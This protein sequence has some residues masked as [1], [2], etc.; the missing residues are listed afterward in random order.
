MR[1]SARLWPGTDPIAS[2]EYRNRDLLESAVG[3]PFH[4]AFG[5]DAYPTVLEK[6]A[7]LFHS[8]IAN[9]PFHNGN[10]RTAVLAF[11][12]FLAA[13]GYFGL[14]GNEA[15][16]KLAEQTASYKERGVSHADS[17]G[18]IIA[19]V[20]DWVVPLSAIRD[21]AKTDADIA[22]LYSSVKKARGRIR[23]NKFNKRIPS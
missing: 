21:A 17:L 22:R 20:R 7:A 11:D 12:I 23:R 10:K 2:G 9:H 8:L 18:E 3:R 16:Y 14:L 15:M 1:S 13:N 6:A 5:Q 19:A 4:S